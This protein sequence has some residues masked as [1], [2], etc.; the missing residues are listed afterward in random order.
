MHPILVG[1]I[2]RFDLSRSKEAKSVSLKLREYSHQPRPHR[3]SLHES[4]FA[5]TQFPKAA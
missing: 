4:G 3:I 2:L 5:A 1:W